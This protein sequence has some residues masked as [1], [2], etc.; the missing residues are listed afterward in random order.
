VLV[1]E[2]PT[3]ETLTVLAMDRDLE[4]PR[5]RIET[6]AGWHRAMRPKV[7]MLRAVR[8]SYLPPAIEPATAL[9]WLKR[10]GRSK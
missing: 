1:V 7:Q 4:I 6:A 8:L 9:A 10:G 2:R 5:E 3:V